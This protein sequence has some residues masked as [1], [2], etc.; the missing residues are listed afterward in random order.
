MFATLVAAA[1]GKTGIFSSVLKGIGGMFRGRSDRKA[2]QREQAASERMAR[3]QI[4]AEREFIGLEANEARTTQ[5]Q[6]A[7]LSEWMRQNRR[8]EISR[9]SKNF[10]Q[11]AGSDLRGS[12]PASSPVQRQV[13]PEEFISSG[14]I[15]SQLA[16]APAQLPQSPILDMNPNGNWSIRP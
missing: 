7:L 13:T 3:E 2:A 5:R 11:F 1:G 12:T 15:V 10:T 9:G 8:S 14:G 4:A 16:P 6:E